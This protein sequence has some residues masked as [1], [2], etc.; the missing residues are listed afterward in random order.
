MD[1]TLSDEQRLLKDSVER[2]MADRYS[3]DQRR[4]Y[5]KETG[6]WSNE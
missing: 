2:L 5:C 3:F 4:G 6:G 1:F